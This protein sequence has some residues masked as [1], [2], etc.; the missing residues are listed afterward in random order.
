VSGSAYDDIE[1]GEVLWIKPGMCHLPEVPGGFALRVDEFLG[2]DYDSP[3][4]RRVWVRGAVLRNGGGTLRSLVLCVPVNQPRAVRRP[5]AARPEPARA[6]GTARPD[7]GARGVD[8]PVLV[9]HAGRM[10]RRV[11][12]SGG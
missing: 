11:E 7:D 2:W 3:G 8:G 1:Q 5:M 9:E 4:Q 10:Y 6:V 12:F